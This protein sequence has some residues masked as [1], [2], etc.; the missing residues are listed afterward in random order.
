MRLGLYYPIVLTVYL[1][2]CLLPYSRCMMIYRRKV[3]NLIF[4]PRHFLEFSIMISQFKLI[5]ISYLKKKKNEP[6]DLCIE[7]VVHITHVKNIYL[8][9]FLAIENSCILTMYIVIVSEQ[10]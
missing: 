3:F 5:P 4:I 8:I 2:R 7:F 9:K 6:Y 1:V 10:Y